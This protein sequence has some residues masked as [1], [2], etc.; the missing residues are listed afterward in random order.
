MYI[1]RKWLFRFQHPEANM[2]QSSE[3][4]VPN[5][6]PV[7]HL[8]VMFIQLRNAEIHTYILKWSLMLKMADLLFDVYLICVYLSAVWSNSI[9]D[10]ILYKRYTIYMVDICKVNCLMPTVYFSY[11]P[12]Y[13]KWCL[14]LVHAFAN[15]VMIVPVQNWVSLRYSL[16]WNMTSYI[17]RGEEHTVLAVGNAWIL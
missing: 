13:Q 7:L 4:S 2:T 5:V 17:I 3:A 15:F 9:Q 1:N 6:L 8:D 16:L 11:K 10:V 12:S 14:C